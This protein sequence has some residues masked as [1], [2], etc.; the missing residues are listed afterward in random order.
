MFTLTINGKQYTYEQD[1]RLLDIP[2]NDL[3]LKSAKD[4]CSEGACGTCTVLIDGKAVKACVQ[5]LSRLDGKTVQTVESLTDYEK[6]LYVY[7]YGAAGAVQCGFCKMCIRDRLL[8]Q[9]HRMQRLSPWS[10]QF[11]QSA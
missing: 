3:G 1:R 4:G 6:K 10:G 5:K 7:A 8:L 11:R 9:H 2:R